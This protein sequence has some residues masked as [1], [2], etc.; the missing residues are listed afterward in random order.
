MDSPALERLVAAGVA[1]LHASQS[2][3][4][5]DSTRANITNVEQE[6]LTAKEI[7][8][9]LRVDRKT[10]YEYAARHVIPCRRLGRRLVF[11]RA[12]VAAW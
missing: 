7:A 11:S 9:W 2:E 8:S 12:A 5:S 6:C 4:L 3:T 1:A 10:V